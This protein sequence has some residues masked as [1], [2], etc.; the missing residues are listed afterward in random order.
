MRPGYGHVVVA[1]WDTKAKVWI[2]VDPK[3]GAME[4]TALSHRYGLA[5]VLRMWPHTEALHVRVEDW[6][7]RPR[8]LVTCVSLAKAAL[9][10]GGW[11][12][13]PWQ[14]RNQLM[15]HRA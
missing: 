15:E 14:L 4:I 6:Q 3:Y 8:G 12:V 10:I 5:D 1:W 11:A 7:P 13:T 2:V 9:G